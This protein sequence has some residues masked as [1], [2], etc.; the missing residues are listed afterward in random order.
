MILSTRHPHSVNFTSSGRIFSDIP[1]GA[2]ADRS[3]SFSAPSPSF[4]EE[5]SILRLC[6]KPARRTAKK[7]AGETPFCVK[8]ASEM[9]SMTKKAGPHLWGG[10]KKGAGAGG[11]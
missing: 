10:T 11:T 1:H 2:N 6:A 8:K 5:R 3:A 9:L 4:R 7:R